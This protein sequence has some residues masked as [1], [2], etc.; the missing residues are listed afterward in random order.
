MPM[1]DNKEL[2]KHTLHLFEG[3]Y[4]KLARLFPNTTP[5]RV[6]RHLV[7]KTI[8]STEGER[9]EIDVSLGNLESPE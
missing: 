3:D 9:P 4:A 2:Q 5:A 7:H 1:E 8:T 6:I